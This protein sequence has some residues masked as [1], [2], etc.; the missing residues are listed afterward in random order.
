MRVILVLMFFILS[1]KSH[2]FSE[3]EK[4]EIIE[5][6][7]FSFSIF[8]DPD[9]DDQVFEEAFAFCT[10]DHQKEFVDNNLDMQWDVHVEEYGEEFRKMCV[11]DQIIRKTTPVRER[12]FA[13]NIKKYSLFLGLDFN[14]PVS[15]SKLNVEDEDCSRLD[16]NGTCKYRYTPNPDGEM[17]ILDRYFITYNKE[18]NTISSI[19]KTE[20]GLLMSCDVIVN[21]FQDEL[22]ERCPNHILYGKNVYSDKSYD[23]MFRVDDFFISISLVDYDYYNSSICWFMYVV[24]YFDFDSLSGE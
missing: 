3:S 18:T 7:F 1:V 12:L 14:A 8:L 13:D 9:M 5:Y 10:V 15:L 20:S 24:G 19:S 23:Y 4:N 16:H 17:G 11:L 6:A 2:A 21:I 22:N